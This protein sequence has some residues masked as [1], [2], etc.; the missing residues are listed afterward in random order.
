MRL[1]PLNAFETVIIN[2]LRFIAV[3]TRSSNVNVNVS[4]LG[5]QKSNVNLVSR[6]GDWFRFLCHNCPLSSRFGVGVAT[7]MAGVIAMASVIEDF[8]TQVTICSHS[9]L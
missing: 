5:E 3:I 7:I 1:A 2:N 8:E 4:Y 9:I 6:F